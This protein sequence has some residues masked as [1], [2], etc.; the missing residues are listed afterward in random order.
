MFV[1]ESCFE[2]VVLVS[3]TT[4]VGRIFRFDRSTLPPPGGMWNGEGWL[5]FSFEK[6]TNPKKAIQK[7]EGVLVGWFCFN[8]P[9]F[10]V[11][12]CFMRFCKLTKLYDVLVFLPSHSGLTYSFAAGRIWISLQ[13]ASFTW[14]SKVCFLGM[15]IPSTGCNRHQNTPVSIGTSK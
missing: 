2:A 9:M 1:P 15:V 5:I 6:K 12:N 14:L 8:I 11:F 3:G 10:F 4:I 7:K 13:T